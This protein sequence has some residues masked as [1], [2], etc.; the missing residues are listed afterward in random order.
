MEEGVA[1]LHDDNGKIDRKL[2]IR[3]HTFSDLT[4]TSPVVFLYLLKEC[5]AHGEISFSFWKLLLEWFSLML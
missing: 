5:Y 1:E 4:Y 2:T 3:A